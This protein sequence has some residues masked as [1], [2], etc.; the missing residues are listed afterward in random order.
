MS[1]ALDLLDDYPSG[2]ISKKIYHDD[3]VEAIRIAYV[4]AKFNEGLYQDYGWY[5]CDD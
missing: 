3:W 2:E 4:L 5:H 1:K